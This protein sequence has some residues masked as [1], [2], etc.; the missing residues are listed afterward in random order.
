MALDL[1]LWSKRVGYIGA[2]GV[3]LGAT[4]RVSRALY[5][6]VRYYWTVF[7]VLR[8]ASEVFLQN[9]GARAFVGTLTD[10]ALRL[11]GAV[12]IMTAR[13]VLNEQRWRATH[14]EDPRAMFEA[15]DAFNWTWANTT[16]LELAGL[17]S[18]DDVLGHNW[19]TCCSDG[20]R[21]K[22]RTECA[23]IVKEQTNFELGQVEL[24]N[25]TRGGRVIVKIS[26]CI[27]RDLEGRPIGWSGTVTRLAQSFV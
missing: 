7:A 17:R 14:D 16:L 3:G 1:E 12:K 6:R 4:Y 25:S 10:A 21:E 13:Q 18:L 27:L 24:S 2:I 5:S 9:G 22:V 20:W 8:E 15:D 23:R 26:A 19:I 11:E